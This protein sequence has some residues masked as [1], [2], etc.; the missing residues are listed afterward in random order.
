MKEQ[1]KRFLE[2]ID[3]RMPSYFLIRGGRLQVAPPT[4]EEYDNLLKSGYEPIGD[5]KYSELDRGVLEAL[6]GILNVLGNRSFLL[7]PL[8]VSAI[9]AHEAR[10]EG[11]ELHKALRGGVV[12]SGGKEEKEDKKQRRKKE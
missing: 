6:T 7:F 2:G 4:A 3:P 12:A 8:A 9:L 10:R 5:V 1:F 11:S